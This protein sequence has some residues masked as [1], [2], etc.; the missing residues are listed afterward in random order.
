[1]RIVVSG[2]GYLGAVH[3]VGMAELGFDVLGL[4]VSEAKVKAFSEGTVPFYEPGLEP[5]LRKHVEHGGL[6]FTTS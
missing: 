3:A 1:M 6:R 5:V 2:T 4:D